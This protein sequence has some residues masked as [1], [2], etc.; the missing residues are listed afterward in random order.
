[1]PF[2]MPRPVRRAAFAALL[3][4]LVATL[5]AVPLAG[6]RI[7]HQIGRGLLFWFFAFF[8]F[9]SVEIVTTEGVMF[10]ATFSKVSESSW[11]S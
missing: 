4:S 7:T 2:V 8:D 5:V 3:T 9:V 6:F 1:M 11:A 10:S